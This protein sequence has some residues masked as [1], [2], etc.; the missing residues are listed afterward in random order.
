MNVVT[1]RWSRGCGC[2]LSSFRIYHRY[3]IVGAAR[4]A[5]AGSGGGGGWR[6]PNPGE[7]GLVPGA[8]VPPRSS[9]VSSATVAAVDGTLMCVCVAPGVCGGMLDDEELDPPT[10]PINQLGNQ[11]RSPFASLTA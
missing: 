8:S 6:V 1:E 7:T 2:G 5:V 10:F 4:T 11:P 9:V 3:I